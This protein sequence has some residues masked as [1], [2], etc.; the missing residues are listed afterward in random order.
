M[1]F[2][3]W[4]LQNPSPPHIPAD[5]DPHEFVRANMAA[6][7][8]A[9]MG[10]WTGPARRNLYGWGQLMGMAPPFRFQPNATLDPSQIEDRRTQGMAMPSEMQYW[11]PAWPAYGPSGPSGPPGGYWWELP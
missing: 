5:A 11:P 4:L 10:N 2:W 6:Y 9:D 1:D 8:L 7:L 3:Q